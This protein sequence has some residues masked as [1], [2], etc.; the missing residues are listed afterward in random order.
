MVNTLRCQGRFPYLVLFVMISYQ[1]EI[2]CNI[3]V[4][5][6]ERYVIDFMWTRNRRITY[7]GH[8]DNRA[9]VINTIHVARRICHNH[10]F[11][12]LVR[13]KTGNIG[14]IKQVWDIQTAHLDWFLVNPEKVITWL[15][16]HIIEGFTYVVDTGERGMHSP[17]PHCHLC[18]QYLRQHQENRY[19]DFLYHPITY[20][21]SHIS[22][23]SLIYR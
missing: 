19:N 23:I 12:R 21:K 5:L 3:V 13:I 6:T 15:I 8:I 18:L 2:G 16:I 20:Y 9:V 14:I 11:M 4:F 1:A 10:A 7:I 22:I 17:P